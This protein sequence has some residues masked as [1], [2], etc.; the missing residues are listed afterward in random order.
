MS[1]G[2]A[3][4]NMLFAATALSAM[5][6]ALAGGAADLMP[7]APML[8][9]R[10]FQVVTLPVAPVVDGDLGEWEGVAAQTI[11]IAPTL[12]QD[13]QNR[14]GQAEVALR[15]GV[16]GD[17]VYFAARWADDA[18]D[19]KF[20]PW[21]WREGKYQRQELRDDQFVVRFHSSGSYDACMLSPTSYQVDVWRW[22]AGRSNLAGLA[23]DQSHLISVDPVEDASEFLGPKGTTYLV[24]RNDAGEPFYKNT[25]APATK[26]A[27]ELPG[28]EII[29]S[30]AGSLIDVSAKGVWRDGFW[31][32]ELSRALN[33]GHDDDV[34]LGGGQKIAGAIG[35]F[36]RSANEHKSVS[37]TLN[38]LFP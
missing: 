33:T 27:E 6:W 1:G 4:R 30:G 22:S 36:N 17:R 38:F 10:D 23:E 8:P 26:G 13:G 25:K 24:K 11:P 14:V 18:P 31:N 7:V 29:G 34:V 16:H 20:R 2:G 3:M 12:E 5:T 19:E 32:L 9:A 35:V 21:R 37:G 15:V 28:I